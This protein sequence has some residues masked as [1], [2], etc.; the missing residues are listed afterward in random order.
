ML[1][2]SPPWETTQL[3][4][5]QAY[6]QVHEKPLQLAGTVS[7][8]L[9]P[10]PPRQHHAGAAGGEG[11]AWGDALPPGEVWAGGDALVGQVK[12]S[13]PTETLSC[14]HAPQRSGGRVQAAALPLPGATPTL[15]SPHPTKDGDNNKC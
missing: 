10:G 6:E 12:G 9:E 7:R 8:W 14:L 3:P 5:E 4:L 2:V 1:K 11:A 13:P 15:K